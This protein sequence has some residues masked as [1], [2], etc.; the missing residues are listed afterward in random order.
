MI[1]PAGAA[2]CW[3]SQFQNG[4]DHIG[5][6]L[7]W[8][9]RVLDKPVTR[10]RRGRPPGAR[11]GGHLPGLRRRRRPAARA[12]PQAD[13]DD[14]PAAQRDRAAGRC[15][16]A[17]GAPRRSSIT[18]KQTRLGLDLKGGVELVYQGEPTPQV[19]KVTPQAID[20][21]INTIR[22]RTDALGVS[23]PEIQRSGRDQISIGLPDVKNAERAEQQ[24]GTTAQLQF[25]DWEPNVFEGP[26]ELVDPTRRRNTRPTARS[27]ASTR[28]CCAARKSKPRAEATDVP[29]GGP[30]PA[31]VRSSTATTSR[32]SSTTTSRTTP[33]ATSTTSSVRLRRT[34]TRR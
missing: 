21:A 16:G 12:D 15:C 1:G 11:E 25:Y 7:E 3:A 17:A 26:N 32:S 4:D 27:S 9:V 20:D 31:I 6:A 34:R 8:G 29:A 22:K 33:P 24:V 2:T 30:D 28:R 23:E 13:R 5:T 18:R 19:P 14:Q 10:A